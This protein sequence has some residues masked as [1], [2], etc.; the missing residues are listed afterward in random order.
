MKKFSFRDAMV[1]LI[2]S[3]TVALAYQLPFLRFTFYD[4]FAA[5]YQLSNT[6]I[7]FLASALNLTYTICYPIGGWMADRFSMRSMISVTLA[8][9]AVLTF[10]F[11]MTTNFVALLIIHVM[12][13][14]FGIATLWSAYLKGIRNL[15]NKDNQSKMFGSS[16]ALRGVIQTLMGFAFLGIVGLAATEAAGMKVLFIFGAVVCA[17]FFVLALFFLPKEDIENEEHT[18]SAAVKYSVMDVLKNKGVWVCILVIMFAYITWAIGNAYM[19]TYT[20][21]VLNISTTTA[22]AIGIIRSYIIVLVAGIL[23]GIF[24]DKFTYKGKGFLIVFV[25][26]IASL[27][28]LLTSAKIVA[29]SIVLT[30]VIAFLANMLKSTY[31]SIMDQA[32]IPIGMTGL[33][34]GIISFIAFIPD[35]LYGPICGKWLDDAVASGDVAAG[36]NKIFIL[37]IVCGALGILSSMLLTKRTKEVNNGDEKIMP[38]QDETSSTI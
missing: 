21:Q 10:A 4:Q 17:I 2:L 11:A 16:E 5:A 19:T 35:V 3:A 32:G 7:G 15:A 14:F 26:I 20:V 12:Y 1:F 38:V 27:I 34:T 37:L 30:L 31:W 28:A 8:A 9:Y 24:M 33:A 18:Q 6:Q 22:S 25:A 29:L 36:F 13:G 23:G